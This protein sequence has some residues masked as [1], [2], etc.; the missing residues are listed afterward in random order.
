MVPAAYANFFIASTGAAAA[1]A[2]LLFIAISIAPER[3]LATNAPVRQQTISSSAFTAL[4]NAF[5]VSLL[6]LIPD[7][8]LAWGLL[9]LGAT[10]LLNSCILIVNIFRYGQ[11][12]STIVRNVFLI[13][14]SL[15]LYGYEFYV[16]VMALRNPGDT[17]NIFT[18]TILIIGCFG[19]GLT[20][21]WELLGGRSNKITDMLLSLHHAQAEN[22]APPKRAAATSEIPDPAAHKD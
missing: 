22:H 6:A 11:D 10:G 13:L 21:S 15:G 9:S 17:G 2:G 19:L 14:A 3:T 12:R 8:N 18:A 1:L 5:F 7:V 4:L 16:G 20:R